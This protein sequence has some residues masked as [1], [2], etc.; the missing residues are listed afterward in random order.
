MPTRCDPAG[1][2]SAVR[3]PRAVDGTTAP[4]ARIILFA[5]VSALIGGVVSR[6]NS[7]SRNFLL[8]N[9]APDKQTEFLRSPSMWPA[10][11][12]P[13]QDPP[14]PAGSRGCIVGNNPG[15]FRLISGA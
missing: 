1:W 3:A 10:R 13:P 2:N 15:T 7:P 12:T 9:G 11:W 14:G 4:R 8:A 5:L 6:P